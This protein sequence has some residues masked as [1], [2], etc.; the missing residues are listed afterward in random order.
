MRAGP[1]LPDAPASPVSAMPLS[2]APVPAASVPQRAHLSLRIGR[3][4]RFKADARMTPAGLVAVGGL[5]SSI[6]LSTAVLVTAATR[7]AR[8]LPSAPDQRV[9]TG[10]SPE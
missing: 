3:R 9:G 1:L 8:Q 10:T 5:V 6:L 2:A 4:F 7:G